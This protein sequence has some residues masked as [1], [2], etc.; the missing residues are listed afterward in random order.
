MITALH[1]VFGRKYGETFIYPANGT[2]SASLYFSTRV[3]DLSI[4]WGDGSTINYTTLKNT[5][6][7][8]TSAVN[9]LTHNYST[10]FI[11]NII[12]SS[13]IVN[14][15][16]SLKIQPT[17][18]DKLNIQN[19]ETFINQFKNLY[20]LSITNDLNS[21]IKR[22]VLKGD[23]SRI[24]DSIERFQI[25]YLGAYY[26]NE[27]DL[28]INLSNFNPTSKLKFFERRNLNDYW[29]RNINIYGDLSKIPPLVNY[30]SVKRNLANT[31]TYTAGRIWASSF[32]TLDI[33]NASLSTAETDN[34]LIDMA[35]SIT[36]AIGGKIIR[37]ANCYRTSASNT[38][39]SYLQSLGF[40]ITVAGVI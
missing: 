1:Q 5:D 34:L 33:G 17:T 24:P 14:D 26:N 25:D 36:T 3:Y 12:I 7:T 32:D 15:I 22:A 21:D 19:F 9:I 40:T 37:L 23:L 6:F 18:S 39:V 29:T 4:N 31:L 8:I 38:A 2:S 20:S 11:G 27:T 35:N 16:Y 30:F 10:P 28:Y 13:N